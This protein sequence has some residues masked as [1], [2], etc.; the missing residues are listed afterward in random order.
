MKYQLVAAY[1]KASAIG[2]SWQNI[3]IDEIGALPMNQIYQLYVK[4]Y[5]TLSSPALSENIHIDLDTLRSQYINSQYTLEYV[6][7]NQGNKP[8]THLVEL[9][10]FEKKTVRYEDAFR[11]GYKVHLAASDRAFDAVTDRKQLTEVR[12]T[13]TGTDIQRLFDYTLVTINGFLHPTSCD[14]N[15]LYVTNGGVSLHHS[16]LNNI[17][18]I[19]FEEIGKIKQYPITTD[20]IFKLDEKSGISKRVYLNL[21]DIDTEKKTV[22]LSIG[23]Y[24]YMPDPA[25]VR[26]WSDDVYMVDFTQVDLKQ[27]WFESAKYLDLSA[28]GLDEY[29]F[30]KTQISITQLLN[31]HYFLKY[32]TLPQSFIVT[33]DTSKLYWQRHYLRHNNYPGMFTAYKEPRYPLFAANGRMCE[34]WKIYEDEHWAVNV[35]D[36]Y[37]EN[38]HFMSLPHADVTN[39]TDANLPYRTFYHSKGYLLE[40]G[41]DI[42]DPIPE[43]DPNPPYDS[44]DGDDSYIRVIGIDI[45]LY[46]TIT[47]L[48]ANINLPS[49]IT[50]LGSELNKDVRST[51]T[52][53]GKDVLLPSTIYSIGHKTNLFSTISLIGILPINASV[54]TYTGYTS[55]L[56]ATI[57]LVGTE[58]NLLDKTTI[59]FQGFD[60][61]LKSTITYQGMESNFISTITYTGFEVSIKPTITYVGKDVNLISTIS[62][63]GSDPSLFSTITFT[64][65]NI[66]LMSTIINTSNDINLMSTISCDSH[67]ID[68]KSTIIL[69]GFN[70]TLSDNTTSKTITTSAGYLGKLANMAGSYGIMP[71]D[72]YLGGDPNKEA[73]DEYL[74]RLGT[75]NAKKLYVEIGSFE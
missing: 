54:I 56:L 9:P 24:L 60:I 59:T 36:S 11:C 58:Y 8:L 32:L 38:K 69:E 45:N 34:Y 67:V 66:N 31:D 40:I 21:K 6:L 30:D 53:T 57:S 42:P 3:D 29:P 35:H 18:L 1:G 19:S 73:V 41:V 10:K 70:T 48:G 26:Q 2:Y 17:G 37:W 44:I 71:E 16:K 61:D 23:G 27:R 33:V 39:G 62:Y 5:L 25:F 75:T 15:A 51:I 47:Y 74:N 72:I 14:K 43:V 49:T 12:V 64:G 13:R 55:N 65:S 4:V 63:T 50:Y 28:V 46:P 22:L 52:Y 68:L 7:A 20:M